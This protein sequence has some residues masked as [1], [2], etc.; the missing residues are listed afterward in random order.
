MAPKLAPGRIQLY[1]DELDI[2]GNQVPLTIPPAIQR[3]RRQFLAFT[4]LGR[5][6]SNKARWCVLII[7]RA[8]QRY[9]QNGD[10]WCHWICQ[11]FNAI[12]AD[13]EAY[14]ADSDIED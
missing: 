13:P 9:R 5:P 12:H 4:L 14:G 10:P 3:M 2:N 8:W 6:G 1:E 11:R 7:R